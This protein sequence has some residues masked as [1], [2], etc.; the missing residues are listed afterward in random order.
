MKKF[1]AGLI[2]AGLILGAAPAFAGEWRVDTRRC[3]VQTLDR[4]DG[5]DGRYDDRYD[6]RRGDRSDSRYDNRG[7]SERGDSRYDNRGRGE[8]GDS[9]YDNR[10][11]GERITVCS[12]SAFYYVPDRRERYSKRYRTPRLSFTYDS[13][14]RLSYR[15]DGGRKIYVRA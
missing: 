9:R 1:I 11:R 8:R 12:R 4:Y 3:S 7:R 10:G 13:R 5:R 6:N 2:G 14:L 15:F